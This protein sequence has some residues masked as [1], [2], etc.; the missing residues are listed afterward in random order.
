MATANQD[1]QRTRL[2]V[3]PASIPKCLNSVGDNNIYMMDSQ[4]ELVSMYKY[5]GIA[6]TPNISFAPYIKQSIAIVAKKLNI[7]THLRKYLNQ[8][9]LLNV[10]KTAIL[11]LLEYANVT[12]SLVAKVL[13]TK[14][15]RLKNRALRIIYY[16]QRLPTEELHI[17]AKL[18]SLRER[19]SK[20]LLCLSYKRTLD[21][22]RKSQLQGRQILGQQIRST[23]IP[24][25]LHW[26][27]SRTS[28]MGRCSTLWD[29]LSASM[30]RSLI[31]C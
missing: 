3:A 6:M 2:P 30:Q 21:P 1:N 4:L 29:D 12:Y 25:D 27:G 9:T 10:Y 19:A 17:K 15:Q 7:L 13:T 8:T 11:P 22:E 31:I 26:R 20:H 5:L 14:L 28:P 23:S 24:P 18:C 16:H